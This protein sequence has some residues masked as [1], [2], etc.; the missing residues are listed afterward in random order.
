MRK[1][2]YWNIE[3]LD[4]I[5]KKNKVDKNEKQHLLALLKKPFYFSYFF[6][7]LYNKSWFYFFGKKY[8]ILNLSSKKYAYQ[9]MLDY[10]TRLKKDKKV[11]DGLINLMKEVSLRSRKKDVA[12]WC[13]FIKIISDLP[14]KCIT[15]KFLSEILPI[16]L[17]SKHPAVIIALTD[18]L[19]PKLLTR[20]NK[21]KD[22]IET[23]LLKLLEIKYVHEEQFISKE[24]KLEAIFKISDVYYLKEF[25]DKNIDVISKICGIEFVNEIAER[26][27]QSLKGYLKL[28]NK[29]TSDQIQDYSYIWY[30]NLKSEP[31]LEGGK[32]KVFLTSLL[33][34][35]LLSK[36]VKETA[37]LIEKFLTDKYPYLL[38]KRITIYI[39]T[40]KY[41]A[42][43]DL[44]LPLV[45]SFYRKYS[46]NEYL[47]D[48]FR[49][50][51][52]KHFDKLPDKLKDEI[53][54]KIS[55]KFNSLERKN[56]TDEYLYK[57]EL[58]KL[59]KWCEGIIKDYSAGF[60]F[61]YIRYKNEIE[62]INREL[63]LQRKID[64]LSQEKEIREEILKTDTR[65][66]IDIL[67]KNNSNISIG[68]IP[69]KNLGEILSQLITEYPFKFIEDVTY[70]LEQPSIFKSLDLGYKLSYIGGF[71][72]VWERQKEREKIDIREILELCWEIVRDKDFWKNS[73]K[74]D[75]REEVNLD[76]A[77]WVIARFIYEGV[78][79]KENAFPAECFDLVERI[80]LAILENCHKGYVKVV[81]KFEKGKG[82]L[83]EVINNPIGIAFEALLKYCL[84]YAKVNEERL[85][86]KPKWP[87]KKVKDIFELAIEKKLKGLEF[88]T[89]LGLFF[90]NLYYLDRKWV[91]RN[92]DKI[93]AFKNKDWWNAVMEGYL[94]NHTWFAVI[95][96][97]LRGHGVYKLALKE[98]EFK[99][100][101][102]VKKSLIEHI[103]IGYLKGIECLKGKDSLFW[104]VLKRWRSDEIQHIISYF[105]KLRDEDMEEEMRKGIQNRIIEFWRHC[106]KKYEG[107]IKRKNLSDEDEKILS[108]LNLLAVFLPDL[109]N[110]Y[111][112]LLLQSSPF[113]EKHFQTSFLLKE[114]KRLVDDNPREVGEIYLRLLKRKDSLPVY[115]EEEIKYIIETI[116]KKARDLNDKKLKEIADK[117]C[118]IYGKKVY[119][120]SG[121]LEFVRNLYEEYNPIS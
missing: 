66:R 45:E 73:P 95:Y 49:E 39:L 71:T 109:K 40:Q 34:K 6:R 82:L 53:V 68:F 48:G 30:E 78:K 4:K 31:R 27:A 101:D 61:I 35:I 87:S 96:K 62:R 118:I 22:L 93:F 90:P 11:I 114:F 116:Y 77:V 72:N 97:L 55:K 85:K 5:I 24:K 115:H 86:D 120:I 17:S 57:I 60:R 117:I 81:D 70:I 84:I 46:D 106:Y 98:K 67:L 119:V 26:L 75:K 108:D 19:L 69:G 74:N 33:K 10:L 13:A 76:R 1:D 29:S 9:A 63:E 113:A 88:P 80:L 110:D 42:D 105:W 23:I 94:W 7:N 52:E 47:L 3:F 58:L 103:C 107:K 102:S 37:P 51:C 59:K 28:S 25:I 50:F 43:P 56:F 20:P 112:K 65:S 16:W 89:L 2:F 41:E 121:R 8:F 100:S 14:Q 54:E 21:N 12:T 104:L 91:E 38:F 83:T 36:R 64:Y 99:G 44:C 92:F 18:E 79:T 111:K 15:K 32:P